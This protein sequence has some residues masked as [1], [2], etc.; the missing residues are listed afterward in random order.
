VAVTD[1]TEVDAPSAVRSDGG[2]D[3][4]QLDHRAGRN[5]SVC[6]GCVHA[7]EGPATTGASDEQATLT[8]A[9][10]EA[11]QWRGT[12]DDCAAAA[13]TGTAVDGRGGL[14]GRAAHASSVASAASGRHRAQRASPPTIRHRVCRGGPIVSLVPYRALFSQLHST[15]DR[16]NS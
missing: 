5:G 4:G 8:G 10:G 1:A 16:L 9:V 3:P 7:T 11:G 2:Q 13:G 6:V 15:K 14:E 12:G